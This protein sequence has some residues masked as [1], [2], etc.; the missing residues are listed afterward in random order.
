MKTLARE[1]V[2]TIR[3]M[4]RP[5]E[6][7]ALLL[8]VVVI[9][10][11]V[12]ATIWGVRYSLA[13]NRLAAGV[14]DVTFYG[15]DGRPWFRLDERRRD[16]PLDQISPYLQQA[17]IAT[18]D[19]RFYLHPGIDPL[20]LARAVR[21][22][23]RRGAAVEGA[24][25]LTQ[26]LART[27]FLSNART[28]GRKGQEAVLAL[29]IE[30]RLSKRQILELYLNRVYLSAGVYGVE[31]MS[32]SLYGKHAADLSLQEAALIAGLV[33]APSALSPW[34][35]L[36]GAVR[37]S[38]HVLD[39]MREA[40]FI[41]AAEVASAERQRS[42][43]KPYPSPVDP[44]GGYAK[45]YLR[46]QFRDHFGG[47]QPAD[48]EVH[49]TVLPSLQDMA[50]RSVE[51]GLQHLGVPTAQAAL[52]ALDP[53]TGHV[54]AIVGGRDFTS[55]AFNRAVRSR[56]QPGSAFKPF[57][58]AA[59]LQHGLTPVSVLRG[60]AS[61]SPQG[62]EEWTPR[63]VS[64]RVDDELTLRQAFIE[65]NNRAAVAL[66]QR[67][68]VSSIQRVAS[69]LGIRDQPAVPSLALGSGLT[70]PLELTAAYAA[71]PNGGYAVT[72]GGLLRVVDDAGQVVLEEAPERRRVMSDAV[73]YQVLSLMTDVVDRGTGTAARSLGVRFPVGGKT[74]TTND[75]KDAW[76]VGFSAHL[77]VGVW[78]GLDQPATIRDGATGARAALPIWAEFM[79]RA[80]RVVRPSAFEP[81]EGMR[82]VQLCH[83]SYLRPVEQCPVYTEY[84]KEG[85]DVPSGHCQLHGGTFRQN[86]ERVIER[87]VG[88]LLGKLWGKISGK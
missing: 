31:A 62:E 6:I 42:R 29:M 25:T 4:R 78:V 79:R 43:I 36:D 60:L 48:W 51:A 1:F 11:G 72:P 52:V 15:A 66:Q 58:Y 13:I 28:V 73:A 54:L 74:G 34:T 53:E 32:L 23:V 84:F 27:L 8:I 57:V 33:K 61:L 64:G 39:R 24:S 14:G 59:A 49:T 63:N 9:A 75:F 71:F 12:V 20:G 35:N 26:Q 45:E 82:A 85:D 80:S 10:L 70:T 17:I 83:V 7:A 67:V 68:G 30:T 22:N 37:R 19:R 76:F 3:K 50:E 86:A 18:E 46:Q 55:S 77:V 5:S 69:D 88:G 87:V 47:D 40:G 16:V 2:A 65:S 38:A 21:D 56:R 44:R 41:S 81:P